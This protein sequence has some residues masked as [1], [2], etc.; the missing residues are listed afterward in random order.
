MRELHQTVSSCLTASLASAAAARGRPAPVILHSVMFTGCYQLVFHVA[1]PAVEQEGADDGGDPGSPG[2]LLEDDLSGELGFGDLDELLDQQQMMEAV[3]QQ[4]QQEL[5]RV[6]PHGWEVVQVVGAGTNSAAAAREAD[7]SPSELDAECTALDNAMKARGHFQTPSLADSDVAVKH[8]Y[9]LFPAAFHLEPVAIPKRCSSSGSGSSSTRSMGSSSCGWS[10]LLE[11]HC[12]AAPLEDLQHQ[13]Y[14][15]LRVV[16]AEEHGAQVVADV[17]QPLHEVCKLGGV[18]LRL[19]QQHQQEA[20][21]G[22]GEG[23]KWLGLVV[24]AGGREGAAAAGEAGSLEAGAALGP[25]GSASPE[26]LLSHLPVPVLPADV[27]KDLQ[28]LLERAV[29]GSMGAAAAYHGVILPIMTDLL[30]IMQEPS[31]SNSSGGRAG[32]AGVAGEAA[33]TSSSSSRVIVR[34]ERAEGGKENQQVL[35]EEALA[36]LLHYFQVHGMLACRELLL[37]LQGPGHA[38]PTPLGEPQLAVQQNTGTAAVAVAAA[39]STAAS[40]PGGH[41]FPDA[42]DEQKP[43]SGEQQLRHRRAWV[44]GKGDDNAESGSSYEP[45]CAGAAPSARAAARDGR[46][47]SA[48][49]LFWWYCLSGAVWGWRDARLE[50]RYC[51][52]FWPHSHTATTVL[53]CMDIAMFCLTQLKIWSAVLQGAFAPVAVPMALFVWIAHTSPALVFGVWSLFCTHRCWC[54]GYRGIACT[55]RDGGALAV[56]MLYA[57]LSAEGLAGIARFLIAGQVLAA[58]PFLLYAGSS[59][60]IGTLR[61]V[62]QRLPPPILL[63]SAAV[64]ALL[65]AYIFKVEDLM[66]AGVGG[67][68]LGGKSTWS[69]AT[70]LAYAQVPVWVRAAAS[71]G[72]GVGVVAWQEARSRA[73]FLRAAETRG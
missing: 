31:N 19:D 39:A 15:Y 14:S 51:R 65:V 73:R 24:L 34:A 71:V 12:A 5:G 58:D 55:L 61:V 20:I 70:A 57:H 62:L 67:V 64:N 48:W 47:F 17:K 7:L 32:L 16:L 44:R 9:P 69:C 29:A 54:L 35:R 6:L 36:S 27:C 4:L 28:Q 50:F 26:L 53:G 52:S 8:P 41:T 23:T 42:G 22:Q 49:L 1:V 33:S 59:F 68:C 63:P 72:L 46:G 40:A 13:G 30:C 37:L 43:L 11:L 21:F 10:G 66:V 60:F 45:V 18:R 2:L 3:E 25:T 56:H 38:A